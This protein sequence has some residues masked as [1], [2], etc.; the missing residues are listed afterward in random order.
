MSDGQDSQRYSAGERIMLGIDLYDDS[1][2]YDVTA[3]F[4]RSDD[5]K[6]YIT[7]PGYGGGAQQAT[8]YLQNVVTTNTPPGEYHCKYIQ[9]QDGR[10][11][12]STLHPDITFYIDQHPASVEDQGPQLQ[13][14]SFPAEEIEVVEMSVIEAER[15]LELTASG[16]TQYEGAQEDIQEG[17]QEDIQEGTTDAPAPPGDTQWDTQENI[18]QLIEGKITEGISEMTEDTEAGGDIDLHIK[19]RI[20]EMTEDT[21]AGSDIGLHIERRMDEIAHD[22]TEETGAEGDVHLHVERRMDEMAQEMFE[23]D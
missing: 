5:P 3:I 2:I 9:A 21:E 15:R 7:L 10:G 17:A 22:V 19:R 8:I 20:G 4:V 23:E 11:N 6:A 14:W 12:Y 18:H 16:T 1:G 13:G